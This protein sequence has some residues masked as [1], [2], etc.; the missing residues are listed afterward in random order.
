L[1]AEGVERQTKMKVSNEENGKH[2]RNHNRNHDG[3]DEEKTTDHF[4]VQESK[5]TCKDVLTSIASKHSSRKQ[6][7]EI[8]KKKCK[9]F[10]KAFSGRLV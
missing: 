10:E 6:N 1:Q 5:Q 7:F 4:R 3:N 2:N 9:D 8:E